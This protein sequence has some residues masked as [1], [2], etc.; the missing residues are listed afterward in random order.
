MPG[1]L[2]LPWLWT[3]CFTPIARRARWLEQNMDG[4]REFCPNGTREAISGP[5]R[6]GDAMASRLLPRWQAES[7]ESEALER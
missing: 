4:V 2:P 5:A 7:V 1:D 3:R 6:Q